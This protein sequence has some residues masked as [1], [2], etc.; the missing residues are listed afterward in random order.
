VLNSDQTAAVNWFT[1]SARCT[2]FKIKVSFSL[3]LEFKPEPPILSDQALNFAFTKFTKWRF[4]QIIK[5]MIFELVQRGVASTCFLFV[6]F[7]M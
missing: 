2:F 7:D 6:W 3:E 5:I 4:V 1:A